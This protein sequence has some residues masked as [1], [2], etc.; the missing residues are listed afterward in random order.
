MRKN[1]FNRTYPTYKKN[2]VDIPHS[3]M[4]DIEN[5]VQKD[6]Y[7]LHFDVKT[8][9]WVL[10]STKTHACFMFD[11]MGDVMNYVGSKEY[12]FHGY[13]SMDDYARWGG[14]DLSRNEGS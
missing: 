4:V 8:V 9:K 2:H 13:G 5:M 11:K 7:H 6:G 3:N 10:R 14:M 1:H 12:Y